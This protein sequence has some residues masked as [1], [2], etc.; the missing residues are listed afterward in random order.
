M[1]RLDPPPALL[2]SGTALTS[3]S[4][5]SGSCSCPCPGSPAAYR[6]VPGA[7]FGPEGRLRADGL[8][9]GVPLPWGSAPLRYWAGT[10]RDSPMALSSSRR[11]C[12]PRPLGDPLAT[13]PLPLHSLFLPRVHGR[14]PYTCGRLSCMLLF[15][16]QPP[17]G[18]RQRRTAEDTPVRGRAT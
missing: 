18:P 14:P 1:A 9:K 13:Q 12:P 10:Q 5:P 6:E 2:P 11:A 16:S 8:P 3:R 17:W 7:A 4:C 15:R